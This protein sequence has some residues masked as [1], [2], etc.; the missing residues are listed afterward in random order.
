M[1]ENDTK[2]MFIIL[3]L[4]EKLVFSWLNLS[5]PGCAIDLAV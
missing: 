5:F 4:F 3:S 1:V 2:A